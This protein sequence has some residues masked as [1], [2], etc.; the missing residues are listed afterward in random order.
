MPPATTL[1]V[2]CQKWSPRAT[3]I[4]AVPPQLSRAPWPTDTWEYRWENPLTLP[5]PTSCLLNIRYEVKR[6]GQRR[7]PLCPALP[8]SHLCAQTRNTATRLVPRGRSRTW[9]WSWSR[10]F[11]AMQVKKPASSELTRLITRAPSDC[12]LCLMNKTTNPL[13]LCL[14]HDMIPATRN[15]SEPYTQLCSNTKQRYSSS[16]V[17]FAIQPLACRLCITALHL[18]AWSPGSDLWLE[19]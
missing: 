7:N 14:S 19:Q 3:L 11:E 1:P 6:H 18:R 16:S 10:P 2:P 8:V 17:Q 4:L 9:R 5:L 12:C 13:S 15:E